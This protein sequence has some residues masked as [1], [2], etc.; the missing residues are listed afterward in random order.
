MYLCD[1]Q[2]SH[3]FPPLLWTS[4]TFLTWLALS[5]GQERVPV[6][7]ARGGAWPKLKLSSLMNSLPVRSSL[8]AS[9]CGTASTLTRHVTARRGPEVVMGND[10]ARKCRCW[11][12]EVDDNCTLYL[13]PDPSQQR[14]LGPVVQDAAADHDDWRRG[15]R[16][17]RT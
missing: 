15:L 14:S 12:V 17:R 16:T 7:E 5:R 11:T 2:P 9:V 1:S 13:C 3:P 6:S 8:R 4:L 10:F